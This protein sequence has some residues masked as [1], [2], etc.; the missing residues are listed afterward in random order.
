MTLRISLLGIAA[1]L[2]S[3]AHAQNLTLSVKF[4]TDGGAT[5]SSQVFGGGGPIIQGAIFMSGDNVYGLGGATL[6]L[7]TTG[8]T[9]FDTAAFG[10]GTDTGRVGPFNFGSATNAIYSTANGFRIDAASDP[11]NNNTAAGMTFF[12]RD[13]S[14]GGA[15]FSTANPALCFRFD[16]QV[17]SGGGDRVIV[18]ALDQLSRG[19]GTYYSSSSAT[20][21]TS[22]S[23][24]LNSGTIITPTP[25][26]LA[27]TLLG[28]VAA[29]RRRRL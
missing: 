7:S 16:I 15:T 27:L 1:L 6:R 12:Q 20:R 17:W 25:S 10:A 11:D 22:A 28:T 29:S 21:P 24:V 9:A 23:V 4:S 18:V 8:G 14:S 26:T 2:A 3:Q 5:W 13:P 19:V